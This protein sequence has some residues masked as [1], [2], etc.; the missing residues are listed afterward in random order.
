MKKNWVHSGYGIVFDGKCR[1]NF[2]NDFARNV[3]IFGFDNSSSSHADNRKTKILVPGE[4]PTYCINGSFDS[5]E[6]MFTNNFSKV[7][8]KLSFILMVI[9]VIY[10]LI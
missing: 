5:R 8:T 7:K 1:W 2:G 9:I 10:L 6:K 3:V 4:G